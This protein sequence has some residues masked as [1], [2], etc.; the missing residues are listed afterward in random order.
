MQTGTTQTGTE[1]DIVATDVFYRNYMADTEIVVNRGGGGSSKSHSLAQLVTFYCF[2]YSNITSRCLRKTRTSAEKTIYDIFLKGKVFPEMSEIF[3]TIKCDWNKSKLRCEFSNG[4]VL[5]VDGL[6]DPHKLKSSESNFMWIE[7]ANDLTWND[8]LTAKMYNRAPNSHGLL[9]QIFIG[10]NP[11]DGFS[12]LKTKLVDGKTPLTEIH[13]THLDNPFLPE[14]SRK[15]YER[16]GEEDENFYRVYTLGEWGQLKG[17][18]YSNWKA[19]YTIPIGDEVIY[20][21][22]FGFNNPSALAKLTIKDLVPYIEEKIYK[23]GLT[24]LQLMEEMVRVGVK[25]N[26]VIYADCA[27]PARIKEMSLPWKD[28]KGEQHPGFNVKEAKKSVMDGIDCVKR[29]CL[30]IAAGA[31]N[32]LKEVRAYKW[33]ERKDG[34]IID[35]P[36]KLLDHIMDAVRY[37]LYTHFGDK[38]KD[39]LQTHDID[40]VSIDQENMWD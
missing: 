21:L 32:I 7:E 17:L 31:I 2:N 20:G 1:R 40:I 10:F 5:T 9:N 22:D 3:P 29:Y 6:D 4:S 19:V 14:Q 30:H 39:D 11:T 25:P 24:N 18:V 16:M 35:E 15:N 26:D 34:S 23:T 12:W 33:K 28:S 13:S 27:E 38:K 37:A 8:W 36:V